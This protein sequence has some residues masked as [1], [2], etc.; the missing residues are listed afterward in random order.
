MPGSP[1]SSLKQGG[2]G[3]KRSTFTGGVR[4]SFLMQRYNNAAS[5][6]RSSLADMSTQFLNK[7]TASVQTKDSEQDN[8]SKFEALRLRVKTFMTV[9]TFGIVYEWVVLFLSVLSC[10]LYIV[11]TY[12]S[13]EISE[14]DITN[15]VERRA[16]LA[17]YALAGVFTFDVLLSFFMAER[18]AEYFTK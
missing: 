13:R 6:R 17:E 12:L 15:P 4:T 9:S 16:N 11:Q 10:L 8:H 18:K 5:R 7:I 3:E 14:T 1:D 2:E